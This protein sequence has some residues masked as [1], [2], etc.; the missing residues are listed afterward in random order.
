[1]PINKNKEFF[2]NDKLGKIFMQYENYFLKYFN[3]VFLFRLSI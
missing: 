3:I 2:K 1:M